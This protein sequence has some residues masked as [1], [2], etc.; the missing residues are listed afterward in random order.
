MARGTKTGADKF[1]DEQMKS[2]LFA[3]SYREARTEVDAIDRMVRA[4]D[5]AREESGLS[6]ADLAAAIEARPEVVRRLFTTKKPNPTLST[7]IRLAG[8]LGYRME[9]VRKTKPRSSTRRTRPAA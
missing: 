5:A 2:P 6:K 7:L 1:F 9:L 4:L 3:K 8:A